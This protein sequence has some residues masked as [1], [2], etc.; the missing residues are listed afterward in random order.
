[1][2]VCAWLPGEEGGH[3]V[4]DVLTG[5]ANP[6]GR[7]PLSFGRGAGQ[8]PFTYL[9][10]RLS[11]GG[12]ARSTSRPVFAFGHGLSYTSFDYTDLAVT[13]SAMATDGT[14]AISC[15]VANRGGRAGDE[16][17]QLYVTDPVAQVARPVQEL[18]GFA[19]V[20]LEPGASTR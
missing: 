9:H 20:T 15:T 5:A 10:K 18:K 4:A 17:V 1:A 13:P 12:Y 11:R 16:I 19:R 7:T 14:V 6:A 8:Q 3:A 2:I